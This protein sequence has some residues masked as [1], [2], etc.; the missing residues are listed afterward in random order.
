MSRRLWSTASA[1]V[2]LVT[3]AAAVAVSAQTFDSGA[4]TPTPDWT[5]NPPPCT[6][7]FA[8]VPCSNF[9]APWIE[10]LYRDG[11]T[12]GCPFPNYCPDQPVTRAQM[13]AFLERTMRGTANWPPFT[14]DV[15]PVLAADGTPDATAS[16]AA[17]LAAVA[18]IPTTGSRAPSGDYPWRVRVG[19]GLFDLGSAQLAL[20]PWVMLEGA[21]SLPFGLSLTTIRS[22]G[23]VALTGTVVL[24][25]WNSLR[26][27]R[28]FNV[29]GAQHAVAVYAVDATVSLERARLVAYG[30]SNANYGLFASGTS[31]ITLD[32]AGVYV[33]GSGSANAGLQLNGSTVAEVLDSEIRVAA[34]STNVTCILKPSTGILKVVRS[35]LRGNSNTNTA[36]RGVVSAQG[37][38]EILDSS[39]Y[40]GCRGAASEAASALSLTSGSSSV[41]RGSTLKAIRED[42]GCSTT[43]VEA[44]N[45]S[46]DISGS[47]LSAATPWPGTAF[48]LTASGPSLTRVWNTTIEATAY[49]TVYVYTGATVRIS[50]SQ[51]LGN[52]ASPAGGTLTCG[53][54]TD[55]NGVFSASTCP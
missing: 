23:T 21:G 34:V 15:Q 54:V 8:D 9:F 39:I 4:A 7:V 3:L 22:A 33:E 20:P 35:T 46:L 38:V 51:L 31:N 41:I 37:Q 53:G 16:G 29:G 44:T 10:Q 1:L 5:F 2:A 18:S 27:V 45:T 19:P 55:E 40:A 32:H 49:N 12:T 14:L 26:D 47:V 13:A 48:G 43:V 30:G 24:T 42:A 52:P 36:A 17:L 6:G 25:G 28:V 50:N 11:V